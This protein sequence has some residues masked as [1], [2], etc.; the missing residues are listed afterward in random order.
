MLEKLARW[1]PRRSDVVREAKAA[2][3]ALVAIEGLA[4]P[5]WSPR[6]YAV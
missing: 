3:G 4:S 6:D 5:A 2:T 1:L